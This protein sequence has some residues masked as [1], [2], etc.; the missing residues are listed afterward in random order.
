MGIEHW[1]LASYVVTV[2]GLPIAILIFTIEQ[3]KQRVNEETEI[4][5][6]LADSYNDFLKLVLANPDLR[7][8]GSL[9]PP[10]R[11]REQ[12]ERIRALYAI[13]ISIFERA[14]VLTWAP[15]MSERDRRYFSSWEDLMGEWCAREDFNA[16]LPELLVGE[17]PEFARHISKLARSMGTKE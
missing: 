4:Q 8:L 2:I 9:R 7:L 3:R 10:G 12:E 15:R 13:L 17:D 16:M 14:F 5:Q 11:V 1:E 6:M